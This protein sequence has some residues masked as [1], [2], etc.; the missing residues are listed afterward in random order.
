MRQDPS[1]PHTPAFAC[2]LSAPFAALGVHLDAGVLSALTFLP[3]DTPL[4]APRDAAARQVAAELS[5]YFSNPAHTFNVPVS[6]AGTPFRLKVWQAL[7][8]IPSGKTLSYGELA[9]LIGSA[10]RAV[11]QALGDNPIPIIIPCHRIVASGG[12]Q[13]GNLGGFNHQRKGF[14]LDIKRWLLNHEHSL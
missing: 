14:S 11:G 6:L 12:T 10:P 5:A 8:D 4:S 3:A 9:R 1:H 7:R 13:R 2:V